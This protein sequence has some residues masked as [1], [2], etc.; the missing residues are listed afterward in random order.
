MNILIKSID[1]VNIKLIFNKKVNGK[2]GGWNGS[3][4]KNSRKKQTNL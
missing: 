4:I 3:H 1:Y 2:V